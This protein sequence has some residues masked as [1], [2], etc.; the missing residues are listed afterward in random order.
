MKWLPKPAMVTTR[1]APRGLP[2]E[3]DVVCMDR[4]PGMERHR[5]HGKTW[6]RFPPSESAC[7]PMW[8][9]ASYSDTSRW[10]AVGYVTSAEELLRA[11]CGAIS[12]CPAVTSPCHAQQHPT[13]AAST[14]DRFCNWWPSSRR[15]AQIL[16]PPTVASAS[17]Q[18]DAQALRCRTDHLHSCGMVGSQPV[19][20]ALQGSDK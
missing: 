6:P 13:G 12:L 19:D 17:P 4:P 3:G 5:D 10:G 15:I 14:R 8:I 7:R 1:A 20:V 18:P 2:D 16:T 9:S 11:M